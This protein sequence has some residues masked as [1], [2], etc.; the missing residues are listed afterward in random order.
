MAKNIVAGTDRRKRSVMLNWT[1][2]TYYV[3]GN[4][5][6]YNNRIYR[7]GTDHKSGNTFAETQGNYTLM[8]QRY[9]SG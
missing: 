9:M 6:I 8:D 2:N 4:V 3:H 7:I 1:R 5:V